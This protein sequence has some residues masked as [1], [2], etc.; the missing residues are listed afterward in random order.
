MQRWAID[1]RS[2]MLTWSQRDHFYGDSV[3]KLEG[4]KTGRTLEDESD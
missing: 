4:W 1:P 2:K 3:P